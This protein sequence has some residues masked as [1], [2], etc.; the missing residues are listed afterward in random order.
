MHIRNIDLN[1]LVIF[2]YLMRE[3]SVSKAA[4]QLGMSQSGVS[5][6]LS[7][8]RDLTGDQLFLREQRGL[9]PTPRALEMIGLIEPSLNGLKKAVTGNTLFDARTD[10][11][12]FT[13]MMS[14]LG[15]TLILPKLMHTLSTKAPNVHIDIRPGFGRGFPHEIENGRIHAA[16]EL[17]PSTNAKIMSVP[18]FASDLVAVTSAHSAREGHTALEKHDYI[19]A[20]HILY[21]PEGLDEPPLELLLKSK[22]IERRFSTTISTMLGLVFAVSETKFI[23]TVPRLL[24]QRLAPLLSIKILE[25]PF[26][27]E[28]AQAFL[29]WPKTLNDTPS[30][31]WLRKELL[32][33]Q[34]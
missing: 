16:M 3:R 6:A 20:Q 18:W 7:R 11:S 34:L 22:G 19:N 1:L 13:L 9:I 31:I 27:E 10:T 14:D 29:W 12:T 8:L 30:N 28:Q 15:E 32:A 23:A 5:H 21:C 2:Q 17:Q 25:L 4:N 26:I 33:Q 24:A